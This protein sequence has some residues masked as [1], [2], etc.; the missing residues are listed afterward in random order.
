[1]PIVAFIVG[2]NAIGIT[3]CM[4]YVC[5]GIW[6]VLSKKLWGVTVT[7]DTQKLSTGEMIALT[8]AMVLGWLALIVHLWGII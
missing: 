4:F 1:M 3:F 5:F 8:S 2:A 7:Q 6:E